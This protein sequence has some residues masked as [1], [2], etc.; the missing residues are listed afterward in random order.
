MPARSLARLASLW[1]SAF[2]HTRMRSQLPWRRIA[3]L[4]LLSCVAGMVAA[5]TSALGRVYFTADLGGG[6]TGVERA[7]LDGGGLELLQLQPTGFEDGLA[8]DVPDGR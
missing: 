3:C 6:G 4:T 7:G 1:G 2:P 8:L 5:P